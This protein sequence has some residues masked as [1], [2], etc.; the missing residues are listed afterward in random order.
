[1]FVSEIFEESKTITGRCDD[2]TIFRRITD[3]V[4]LA[5]NQAKFDISL[6]VLDLCVCDGC[7]T[8]PADVGTVLGVINGGMPTLLRDQW[9]SY[10]AN[11]PGVE[12]IMP[13][14]YTDEV[15]YVTT[16]KDPSNEVN[17]IAEVENARDSNCVL[18]VF[19]WDKEGKRI[20]TEGANGDLEDGFLVPTVF[21]F[22][23]P[24]PNAPR[25]YKIDKIQ[26]AITNGFIK[27]LAVDPLGGATKTTIGYYLP[28]ETTPIYRRVRAPNRSWLRIKYRKKDLDVRSTADWINIESR[29]ALLLL[30]KAVKYRLDNQF[31]TA[32]AAEAAGMKLLS[33]EAESLRPPGIGGP[34]IVWSEGLPAGPASGLFYDGDYLG[35]W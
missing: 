13:W 18:R 17:L 10:H 32:A 28:W 25:I 6:G 31:D 33:D 24:N 35:P 9:Y 22:S 27:L 11:G 1:M 29:L 34:Q 20:Y 8:L 21:G 19:G 4:K 5:N 2:A 12:S 15:G 3:A 16:F 23:I 7:A 26:K 30:L 14:Y